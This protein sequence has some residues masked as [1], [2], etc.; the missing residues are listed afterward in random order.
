[1]FKGMRT[2]IIVSC[3]L[4]F[5]FLISARADQP[6]TPNTLPGDVIAQALR[7]MGITA[8][9]SKSALP[10]EASAYGKIL[11]RRIKESWDWKDKT[12]PLVTTAKFEIGHD[13]TLGSVSIERSSGN[14]EFDESVL[15]A[16]RKA[17]PFPAPPKE[18][19]HYFK[20]VRITVDPRE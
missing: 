8:P 16:I 5:L 11:S 19:Y 17:T 6:P 3:T 2:S 14:S 20:V 12:A 9:D 18:Y 4:H 7:A 13:G 15:A 1:M 10:P